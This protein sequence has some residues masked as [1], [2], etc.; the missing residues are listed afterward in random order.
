MN[1]EISLKI[2][3]GGL[4]GLIAFVFAASVLN[5]L[6]FIIMAKAASIGGGI[7]FIVAAVAMHKYCFGA[8]K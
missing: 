8:E 5:P 3:T 6:G 2:V 1:D 7:S 4:A